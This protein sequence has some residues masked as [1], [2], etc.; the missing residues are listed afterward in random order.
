M[1]KSSSSRR[2]R[3]FGIAV[4]NLFIFALIFLSLS[5]LIALVM[6]FFAMP[7]ITRQGEERILLDVEGLKWEEARHLLQ[8]E[9]F[10]PVR[11]KSIPRDDMEPFR[12]ISQMPRPGSLVKM[13]RR[14]Y[15]DVSVSP[16][17][18]VFPELKGKTLRTAQILMQEKKLSI[19]SV[20]YGFS[21]LPREVIFWQSVPAGESIRP[22]TPVHIKISLGLS[23]W[24]VPN[25]TNKSL[26]E[27]HK[28]INDAGLR[29]GTVTYSERN[30]LL[31]NTVIYQSVPGATQLSVPQAI[32]LM[33]S[34]FNEN[35]SEE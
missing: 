27:A 10:L 19:D 11:G 35:T 14:V 33:V 3:P 15:L 6:H 25:V 16:E 34:R 12:V 23:S 5:L 18:V 22:G 9:K 26:Q 7:A 1:K 13:G 29:I 32:D 24:T 30:D 20:S 17:N 31:P 8:L 28:L 4:K 2:K 21:D